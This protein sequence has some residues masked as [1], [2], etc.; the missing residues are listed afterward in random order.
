MKKLNHFI[1]NYKIKRI[2]INYWQRKKK[3][4]INKIM[5]IFNRKQNLNPEKHSF[6]LKNMRWRFKN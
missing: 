1:I 5:I 6:K 3:I 4:T 2:N